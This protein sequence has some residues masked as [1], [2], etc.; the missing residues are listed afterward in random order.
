MIKKLVPPVPDYYFSSLDKIDFNKLQSKGF[1]IV[2]MDIDNTIT[3]HGAIKPDSYAK[4]QVSRVTETGMECIIFSNAK[5]K[6]ME[7]YAH[8][9]NLE[10]IPSPRKPTSKGIK[11][12]L[13]KRSDL[14][15]SEIVIIG[16]QIFTDTLTG[17]FAGVT[18]IL[19][20]PI[21]KIEPPMVK[22]KRFFESF[23]KKRLPIDLMPFVS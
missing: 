9:I 3:P 8:Q 23:I 10:F 22:F 16:D 4:S 2:L 18:T 7:P 20:D 5:K 6:R 13:N 21:T 11:Y 19:V 1:K 15:K 12:L 17:I 14:D